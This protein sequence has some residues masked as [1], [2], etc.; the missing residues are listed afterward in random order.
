[1]A[2]GQPQCKTAA[3]GVANQID[4]VQV[5]RIEKSDGVRDPAVQ[6]VNMPGRAIGEAEADQVL[7]RKVQ[8][9]APVSSCR[10]DQERSLKEKSHHNPKHKA[11]TT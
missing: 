4:G 11:A 9:A 7:R 5:Q 2:D 3:E 8:R 1:M 10:N 6:T